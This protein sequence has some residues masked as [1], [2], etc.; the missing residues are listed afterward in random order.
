MHM[1]SKKDLETLKRSRSLPEQWSQPTEMKKR[2][3]MCMI[4]IFSSFCSCSRIL[5][6]YCPL[7]TFAKST[8]TLMSGPAVVSQV[9]PKMGNRRFAEQRTSSH[10][11]FQEYH[12]VQPQ[13]HPRHRLRRICLFL[14]IQQICEVTKG[15]RGNCGEGGKLQQRRCSRMAVGLYREPRDRRSTCNRRD[16]S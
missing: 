2:K 5:L 3:C 11:Q 9:W 15:L 14:W 7:A 6:P 12:Q 16:F 13:L 8:V 4:F 1:I 10:C